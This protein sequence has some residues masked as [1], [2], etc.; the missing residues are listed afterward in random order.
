[1][2]R[3]TPV[4]GRPVKKHKQASAL[5]LVL[6]FVVLL[7]AVTVA[8]LSRSMVARQVSNSSVGETKATLLATTAGDI[9]IGDLRQE[10]VDGSTVTSMGTGTNLYTPKVAVS[11]GGKSTAIPAIS[12]FT[13]VFSATTGLETDGLNNLVKRSSYNAWFYSTVTNSNYAQNGPIRAS[14]VNSTTASVNGRVITTARWNSHYLLALSDPTH[15]TNTAPMA[16]FL[17]PDWVIVARGGTSKAYGTYAATLADSSLANTNFA[18]GRYAYAIYD[19]GGLLDMNVAGKPSGLTAIQISQKGSLALADLT[20]LPISSTNA[21]SA[22]TQ[23][24]IDNLVGWRNYASAKLSSSNGT[25][26]GFTFNATAASNWLTNFA[27]SPNGYLNI[28]TPAGVTT[29]PTDQALLSRQQLISLAQSLNFNLNALQYMGTFS[30]SLEQPSFTPDPS[31]PKVINSATPPPSTAVLDT[32]KGNNDAAGGDDVINPAFLSVRVARAFTRLNGTTAVIG[33]PLVKAKF[34]L[35]R[36]ALVKYNSVATAT[37]GDTIYDRFGIS[38]AANTSA[39]TYNHGSKGILTLA[40]VAALNPGREPDFAEMLKA[41]IS[42][43]SLAKAGPGLNNNYCNYQYSLDGSIDFQV[44]QIMANLIDQYDADSYPTQ[45]QLVSSTTPSYNIPITGVEDVPYFYRL[46]T[47]SVVTKLPTT[48]LTPADSVTLPAAVS[49]STSASCSTAMSFPGGVATN[50]N[51]T[52][53]APAANTYTYA[54]KLATGV[55]ITDADRGEAALLYVPD[56]WNPHDPNTRAT[57]SASRPTQYR[58]V[59]STQ[60]P[61]GQTVQSQFGVEGTMSS[62]NTITY[63]KESVNPPTGAGVVY[64][65]PAS[66]PMGMTPSDVGTAAAG[67]TPASA[68]TALTFS[69]NTGLLFREPTMLWNSNPTGIALPTTAPGLVK[70]VLMTPNKNFFGIVAGRT[71]L[72]TQIT[73]TSSPA[74]SFDG[75]YIFQANSDLKV[76]RTQPTGSYQQ[77]TFS[78]QYLD[79]NSASGSPHWITYDWKYSDFHGIGGAGL[80]FNDSKYSAGAYMSPLKNYNFQYHSTCMD[81]RTSRWGFGNDTT[82]GGVSNGIN[83]KPENAYNPP[84]TLEP[85][86]ATNFTVNSAA[87]YQNMADSNFSVIETNRPRADKGDKVNYSNPGMTSDPGKNYQMRLFSG[88]GFSGSNGQNAAPLD[89]DGLLSQNNPALLFNSRDDLTAN[90]QFYFEDADGIARFAMGGYA[91]T[92]MI[93]PSSTSSQASALPVR[94]GLPMATASTFDNFA[95]PTATAQS[96]SRPLILNRAFRSV[97][98]MSY[99]FTGTPW[100][101][102]DFFTP[103]SGDTALL[104]T[105]C[106]NEPPV[107]GL[108]AGKVNLNTR[109]SSVVQ[110]IL[111]GALRD[112]LAVA[113]STSSFTVSP[114]NTSHAPI[115]STEAANVANLLVNITTDTANAWRGPLPNVGA[116]VGRFVATPGT[117]SVTTGAGNTLGTD[118]YT[119]SPPVFPTAAI[120]PALASSYTFSGLSPLLGTNVY[121]NPVPAGVPANAPQ[122]IQRFREAAIRPLAD[123]GQTRVWNLL[124]DVVAQTGRYP[125]TATGLDQFVVEGEKRIWLHVAIDRFTGQVVDKQLEVVA[126]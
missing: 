42:A 125:K 122:T 64:V 46:H 90:Q 37:A 67:T 17:A 30:R 41:S 78:L 93:D 124:I 53:A 49:F 44:M 12:G 21:A 105:F 25:Y 119:Y 11:G 81:P 73:Y 68:A 8:F 24:Q 114:A 118:W 126:Q 65:F 19:E 84:F 117:T 75:N 91:D 112:E 10:I 96:Q 116:L 62:S 15:P 66:S 9:V 106:I 80:S 108:V 35:S 113:A 47:F 27:G 69:D 7:T 38:R 2:M 76:L 60:D 32:Y 51:W 13:P 86:A 87:G 56:L 107:N 120:T 72:L 43:G 123:C 23:A 1:M 22:I 63:L 45:I 34:A 31:R 39:W 40:Q 104:D 54:R 61:A 28:N 77:I 26:N 79:P 36:L 6:F 92:T 71:P 102:I 57:S 98:D 33:E 88:V 94:S 111:A 20:V 55:T 29:P 16:G 89:Y 74:Q 4:R 97:S 5:I 95:T 59:A 115:T 83:G 121:T 18:V 100:K 14:N 3:R 109:Q 48:P 101:N 85:K 58:L 82:L 99:C 103:A 70:N 52:V 50:A 110:A